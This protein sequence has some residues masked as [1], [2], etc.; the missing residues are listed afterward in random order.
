MAYGVVHHFPEGTKEQYSASIVARLN[1]GAPP[2]GSD[3]RGSCYVEFG[4][5]LVGRVD[6]DFLSG[7]QPTGT[8]TEP[9]PA[10]VA[11]K[12]EFG[13]SRRARWFGR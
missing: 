13:A 2:T 5:G 3:G 11:E 9:S 7:P 8:F 10:V 12:K 1:G 6:V 4:E